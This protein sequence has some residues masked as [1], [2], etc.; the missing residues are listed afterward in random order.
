[1]KFASINPICCDEV[2]KR[3]VSKAVYSLLLNEFG[4]NDERDRK[5]LRIIGDIF[6]IILKSGA[7]LYTGER[8]HGRV[9]F[10]AMEFSEEVCILHDIA[11]SII[12]GDDKNTYLCFDRNEL[13]QAIPQLREEYPESKIT[14]DPWFRVMRNLDNLDFEKIFPEAARHSDENSGSVMPDKDIHISWESDEQTGKRI[15]GLET[16]L[17]AKDAELEQARAALAA[18]REEN[19][20][21]NEALERA[22]QDASPSGMTPQQKAARVRSENALARWKPVIRAM[23][24]IAV[25][26]GKEGEKERQTPDLHAYFNEMDITITDEQ[27]KFFRQALPPEY[28]DSVGGSV[29]KI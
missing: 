17:A 26:I 4:R 18:L 13:F 28:K 12:Y 15:A 5:I 16:A 3:Y 1:M 29:G 7:T 9:F 21:L 10:S 14:G 2:L 20:A 11:H 27:M 22:R 6:S 24:Q 19:A 8:V 23:I 25:I